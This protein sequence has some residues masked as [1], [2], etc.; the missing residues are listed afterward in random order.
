MTVEGSFIFS[1]LQPDRRT[2]KLQTRRRHEIKRELTLSLN[3]FGCIKK[4]LGG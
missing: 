1:D 3:E 4:D 2:A